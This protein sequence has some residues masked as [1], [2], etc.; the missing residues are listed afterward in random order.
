MIYK[1]QKV[2][3]YRCVSFGW[4]LLVAAVVQSGSLALTLILTIFDFDYGP[5]LDD[6]H[7]FQQVSFAFAD[8]NRSTGAE[9]WPAIQDGADFEL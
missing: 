1:P 9:W 3:G 4:G 7:H 2:S 5:Y 8:D 6:A